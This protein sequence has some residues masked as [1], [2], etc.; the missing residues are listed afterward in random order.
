MIASN[1]THTFLAFCLFFFWG[2]TFFAQAL[3]NIQVSL[4]WDQA[5]TSHFIGQ[6]ELKIWYFDG[7]QYPSAHPTLPQYS[8]RIAL[9]SHGKITTSFQS[10]K[11]SQFEPMGVIFDI[12]NTEPIIKVDYEQ[13]RDRFFARVSVFPIYGQSGNYEKLNDFLIRLQF[14]PTPQQATTRGIPTKKSKLRNGDIYQFSISENGIH[15]LDANF[16]KNLG[17]DLAS[18]NPQ[19][20]HILGNGGARLPELIATDRVDDLAENAIWVSGE[21][22]G[23]FNDNDFIL[24]NAVSTKPMVKRSDTTYQ[25]NNNPYSDKAYYFLKIDDLAGKRIQNQNSLPASNNIVDYYLECKKYEKDKVNLLDAHPS[26][27]GGGNEWFGEIFKAQKT[28]SFSDKISFKNIIKN[29]VAQMRVRFAGYKY[30]DTNT[31]NTPFAMSADDQKLNTILRATGTGDWVDAARIKDFYLKYTPKNNQ[32]D[33]NISYMVNTSAGKGWLDFIEINAYQKLIYDNEPFIFGSLT[34]PNSPTTFSISSSSNDL[35][36]WDISSPLTPV[37]QSFAQASNKIEFTAQT[38]NLKRYAVFELNDNFP[39]PE[40]IGKI[41]NQNI[42]AIDRADFIIIYHES[43]KNEALK[44]AAHR[45]TY[46]NMKVVTVDINDIYNEFSSGALDP[47]AIRDFAKMVYDRDPNFKYLLLMGDGSYD[48]KNINDN[49]SNYNLI[50]V[51][52]TQNSVDRIDTYPSDDFYAL[53][54]NN[55][56]TYD[57]AGALD[58]AVGRITARTAEEANAIVDKIIYYDTNPGTLKPWRTRLMSI[59]DDGDSNT[60][61]SQA[62]Q[63]ANTTETNH[64]MFATKKVFLD[65][66][67]KVPAP[68]GARFPEATKQINDAV[69]AGT[70]VINYFGHGGAKGLAQER[71]LTLQSIKKWSNILN[72]L[73]LVI[74]ASCSTAGFDDPII[75]TFGEELLKN[76]TGGAIALFS[77]VRPVYSSTNKALIDATYPEIFNSTNGEKRTIGEILRIGK[78]KAGHTHNERKFLLLGDP[79]MPLALPDKNQVITDQINGT[80]IQAVDSVAIA[81]LTKV[82]ITGHIADAQAQKLSNFNGKVYVTIFDKKANF[83]TLG[84]S[85]QPL[86]YTDRKGIIFKGVASVSSGDFQFTFIVPKDVVSH[87]YGKILYYASNEVDA[88]AAGYT[89]KLYIGGGDGVTISDDTPPIVE[90]FMNDESFVSGGVTNDHPTI[91][92]KIS[93]DSGINISGSGV[94]HD[95]TATIDTDIKVANNYYETQT[96]DYTKGELRYPLENISP[97]EHTISVKAWDVANNS[98]EDK[99]TFFVAENEGAALAHVLN[100]PNPFTN[101]TSFQFEHNLSGPARARINIFSV[102]GKIIKTIDKDLSLEGFRVTDIQW[103]GKDDYGDQLAKGVYLYQVK[104]TSEVDDKKSTTSGFEKLVIMK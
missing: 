101:R 50:P 16:L 77:T 100:Y 13:E 14:T 74:T 57:L 20:I 41:D 36:I 9:P 17:V 43:L 68:Y 64:K 11:T 37:N 53:L 89:E 86:P 39:Q 103:D 48:A 72:N 76:P 92:A 31:V 8:T 84:Q 23:K 82:I 90:L 44:L 29:K 66:Y 75:K 78:N 52:E 83:K 70:L 55:E 65:A 94:G 95:L 26:S 35:M 5:P 59:G 49:A 63:T 80:S 38:D 58:I 93:D 71:V 27:E 15:K 99:I 18:I 98:G 33:I 4:Q 1:R 2:Q 56:G 96:D 3:D 61:M 28:Q 6:K 46:S 10:I 54:S 60:H 81:P 91:F 47:T 51:R 97:G 67:P 69:L 40:A 24:F 88:D 73:P 85:N 42:H 30:G 12:D 19:N 79:S 25:I 34:V 87:G 7:A 22:D 45:T 102:D 104:I 21:S 62:D 32:P